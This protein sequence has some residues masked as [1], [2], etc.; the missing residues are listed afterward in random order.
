MIATRCDAADTDLVAA[1]RAG[2]DAAFEELYR[3]Y[4]PRIGAFV[5]RMLGDE[6]RAE[7]VTQE[8]FLSALRRIRATEGEISFKPWIYEIARNAA[9]DSYRRSSRAQEVSMDA[10]A[11]LRP[12]DRLRLVGPAAPDSALIAKERLDHVRGALDEL[13]DVHLRVLVMRELDGL[14]YREIGARLELSRPAVESA[15]LHARQRLESE[16]V[17]LSEGR[18]CQKMRAV[19]G[20]LAEGMG[21]RADEQRLARH[22]RRCQSCRRRA[23][24]LGVEPLARPERLRDKVAARLPWPLPLN[25]LP[26]G[27]Q[28]SA[29][30]G[31]RAAA[32]VAAAAI[33]WVGGAAIGGSGVLAGDHGKRPPSLEQ[34]RAVERDGGRSS[35]RQPATS[36][37]EATGTRARR[38]TAGSRRDA[39]RAGSRSGAGTAPGSG[40]GAGT[41]GATEL[42]GAGTVGAGGL[43]ALPGGTPRTS[44]PSA[45]DVQAPS[46]PETPELSVPTVEAPPTAAPEVSAPELPAPDTGTVTDTVDGVSGAVQDTL[47]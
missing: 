10:E 15:L 20:R 28:M 8:A 39:E 43:P 17:E 47:P 46:L 9:I 22:A 38:D 24:E 36:P 45:P 30:L 1:V 44:L 6:A 40:D 16:Y 27:A 25:W 31:E 32:L 18:R 33:A 19:I 26:S 13:S 42:P 4:Q 14:S 37:R 35:V 7:D 12:S 21:G 29:G 41:A 2:E 3:R 34:R 23:R 11:A 5:R